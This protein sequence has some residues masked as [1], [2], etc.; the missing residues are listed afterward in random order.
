MISFTDTH[1]HIFKEYYDNIDKV[2]SNAKEND[3]NKIIVAGDTIKSNLEIIDLANKYDN[4]YICLGIFP[5][6]YEESLTE[7]TKIVE[8]N[9]N[10]PKFVGFGEIG[11]DYYYDKSHK[12]EQINLLEY[13]LKLAEKYHKPVVIHSRNAT[14]DTINILKKYKVHGVIHCF[15]GSLE[16]AKIYIKMGF[17]FGIGGVM[18]FKNANIGN[19]IKEIP[20][21]RL[22]LETDSPYLAPSPFR[23]TKNEPKNIRVIA[24][25]LAKLKEITLEEVSQHTEENVSDVFDI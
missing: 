14:E 22:L 13:Q 17:Y 3:V 20:L 23:G 8:N 12:K 16:T 21:N 1:S 4:I 7:F 9:I 24:E 5:E 11:L 10:N 6:N 19:V 18:T 15:S 25:Y 2:I